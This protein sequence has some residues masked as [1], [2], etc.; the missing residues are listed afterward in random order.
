MVSANIGLKRALLATSILGGLAIP[1][2]AAF[3]Q[4]GSDVSTT[5]PPSISTATP[6]GGKDQKENS[7]AIIVTGSRIRHDNYNTPSPV[8]IITHDEITLSGA[9]SA[10][11]VLQSSAVTS[12][13]AQVNNTYLGYVTS[14]G[15][16]SNTVGLRGLGADRTLILLNGRRLSPAGTESQVGTAD[17]NTLPLSII[18]H[19]EI[20]KDGASTIYGSDAIAGV[21]NIITKTKEDGLTLDGY[22]NLPLQMGDGSK[23]RLSATYGK[24]FDR[25]HFEISVDYN[26]QNR[27]QRKDRGYAKCP[28]DDLFDPQ[29]GAF[30]GATQNGQPRCLPFGFTDQGIAQDYLIG[31]NLDG[32][33]HRFTPNPSQAANA[34]GSLDGYTLVDNV[35]A[36]PGP[37]SQ[38]LNEDIYSPV[39]NLTVYTSGAYDIGKSG[40]LELY[41]EAL[42]SR[43]LSSQVATQQLS[44]ASNGIYPGYY[45]GVF[46]YQLFPK[47]L[48]NA[49]YY[50]AEPLFILGSSK[51]SQR[52][53]YLRADG[54]IRGDVGIKNWHFDVNGMYSHSWARYT[55]NAT[56]TSRLLD[57]TTLVDAPAGTPSN[58]TVTGGSDRLFPGT[59]TCASNVS[60]GAL[61][62][63]AQ[64]VPIDWFSPSMNAGN[65][66]TALKNWLQTPIIGHTGYEEIAGEVNVDGDLFK[67]PAGPLSFSLGATVRHD[68]L[69]DVPS[70]YSQNGDVFNYSS[71]GI[72]KGTD[73]VYELYGELSIPILKDKPFF[74]DLS[75]IASGRY[76]H[77]RSYGADTTYKGSINWKPADFVRFRGSYGT[78]FRA[79]SIYQLDVAGQTGFYSSSLDPCSDYQEQTLPSSNR[80]KN[81]ATALA[82]TGGATQPAFTPSGGPQSISKGGKGLLKAETSNSLSYGMVLQPSFINLAFTVDYYRIVVNNEVNQLG[83]DILNFCYDS[84]DFAT[85]FYCKLIAPRDQRTGDLTTFNDSFINVSRQTT[86]GIDF[87]LRYSH[88]IGEGKFT[89]DLQAT[90][91]LS[92]NYQEEPGGTV[93]KYNGTLG[94]ADFA[95]GP[96]W[97]SELELLYEYKGWTFRYGLDYVG[98]MNSD[99]IQDVDPSVDPYDFKTGS[100]FRHAISVQHKS[101]NGI[102][103]TLGVQ[104][105][106]DSRPE[107]ISTGSSAPRIGNYF[108]YSGYDFIGR[109][110]VLE[111]VKKF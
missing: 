27:L 14:G 98:P 78:S 51:T 94:N 104:N 40:N 26:V 8:E 75:A 12:G 29:T 7:D 102:E 39:K 37:S 52:D 45:P 55:L 11:E 84:T 2:A 96:K 59:Y 87:N 58:L 101:Q 5:P 63:N 35:D 109:S 25:G 80:Y 76:T 69:N 42:F 54:G 86:S 79:P 65:V 77:Y 3:A 36:R 28:T 97:T 15:P 68:K 46:N 50:L 106:T 81:C 67:L 66:P 57:S 32:S 49:G 44:A 6:I 88:P 38:Q 91:V 103:V 100:Y 60:N 56:P 21:I 13:G 48:N 24:T 30:V 33:A 72:T 31:F 34:A 83:T 92:Q 19:F 64:C 1:A 23:Y 74:K 71:A 85:N 73:L 41:G 105:L 108:D 9:S 93:L 18:D 22:G 70:A 16:G 17:L 62:A 47:A 43:R 95:G 53:N 99:K 107:V 90:R 20:L 4:T 82:G 61:I 10:A 111:V 89:G 110:L